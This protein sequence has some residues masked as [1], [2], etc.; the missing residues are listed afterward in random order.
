MLTLEASLRN[1]QSLNHLDSAAY[2][3][4]LGVV[5]HCLFEITYDWLV[6]TNSSLSNNPGH[7]NEEHHTPNIQHAAN[8]QQTHTSEKLFHFSTVF[9]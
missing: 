6:P 7:S 1:Y 9:I 2:M 4:R 5:V 8:L 3:H